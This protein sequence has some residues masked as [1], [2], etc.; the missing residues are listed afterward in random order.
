MGGWRGRIRAPALFTGTSIAVLTYIGFDGISTLSEEVRDPRRNIL[1]ATVLVCLI[2]GVLASLEVYGAQLVWPYGRPFPD[3]DTAFSYVAG[4]VAAGPEVPVAALRGVWL[5]QL[6]NLTLLIATIGSGS[7][8]QL[9][10]ARLLYGMGRG[11]ALPRRFFGAIDPKRGIPR[12]DVIFTG[13][14]ALVGA[15]AL[16][17]QLAAEMLNFGAF[18]A[19]MGV[20]AASFHRYFLRGKRTIGNCAPPLAGLAICFYLWLSLRTPAKIAGCVW[21]AIGFLYG[22]WKTRGFRDRV[23]SFEV[24]QEEAD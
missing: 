11:N 14:L 20:N 16:T 4:R 10:A 19:F 1:R 7:G 18:I 24:P 5:F 2:T 22:A 6:V 13:G 21:L 12:N 17:Y 15:F 3:V 9:G 23:V 8:A